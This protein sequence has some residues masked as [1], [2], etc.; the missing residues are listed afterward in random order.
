MVKFHYIAGGVFLMI[1][2]ACISNALWISNFQDR[3]SNLLI[4]CVAIVIGFGCI[5]EEL[6]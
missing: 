2:G 5:A 1:A 4:A 6:R 3:A